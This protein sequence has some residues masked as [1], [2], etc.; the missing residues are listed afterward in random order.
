MYL[1][2]ICLTLIKLKNMKK[3]KLFSI[4]IALLITNIVSAQFSISGPTVVCVGS[5]T[6]YP[7]ANGEIP[8][9]YTFI[10]YGSVPLGIT[11]SSGANLL[12]SPTAIGT[13]E[14]IAY[15][16]YSKLIGHDTKTITEETNKIT[17][18]VVGQPQTPTVM[19][20]NFSPCGNSNQIYNV[21]QNPYS[22]Y[23]WVID[24]SVYNSKTD[25][26]NQTSINFKTDNLKKIYPIKVIVSQCGQS[27]FLEKNIVL[28][29]KPNPQTVISGANTLCELTNANNYSV[30]A[31]IDITNYCWTCQLDGLFNVIAN[32]NALSVNVGLDNSTNTNPVPKIL[33]VELNNM[34]G[35]TVIKK[36]IDI[37]KIPRKPNVINGIV[38]ITDVTVNYTYITSSNY[39]NK[40][41]WQISPAN[42]G[43]QINDKSGN[44][45]SLILNINKAYTGKINLTA[46]GNN[47]CGN[48]P[49]SDEFIINILPK[50]E[51]ATPPNGNLNACVNINDNYSST[52]KY[53]D[54]YE[55]ELSP[56]NAG[57][58]TINNDKCQ[59]DW[60][61]NFNGAA[62]LRVRG[63]NK[64]GQGEWSNNSNIVIYSLPTKPLAPSGDLILCKNPPSTTYTSATSFA[65]TYEW[66]L[67]PSNAGVIFNNNQ[68]AVVNWDDNY[69][70]KAYLRVK[71]INNCGKGEWSEFTEILISTTAQTPIINGNFRPCAG[72]TI[73]YNSN[74]SDSIFWSV[75]PPNAYTKLKVI[76]KN[77]LEITWNRDNLISSS[78]A[79]KSYSKS[80]CGTSDIKI[81]SIYI[82]RF[83]TTGAEPILLS[84]IKP[85]YCSSDSTEIIF[86]TINPLLWFSN[87]QQFAT[88]YKNTIYF[89]TGIKQINVTSL[90][91][92]NCYSA[93]KLINFNVDEVK[94]DFAANTIQ[95]NVGSRVEFKNLSSNADTYEW[96]F[97]DNSFTSNI[98]DDYHTFY[99]KGVFTIKLTAISKN[100]CQ[101]KMVKS[102]YITV[103]PLSIPEFNENELSIFPNPFINNIFIESSITDN[104]IITIT[105]IAG[106]TVFS[107]K[108]IKSIKTE[109]FIEGVYFIKIEST[110]KVKTYKLI[111]L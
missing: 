12:F 90:L 7:I 25:A 11:S 75:D 19:Y 82:N 29:Q 37:Y 15:K 83:S 5:K 14:L 66:E 68:S 35:Q 8:T 59:I 85:F 99:N 78:A 91:A 97:G 10:S 92:N 86:N 110:K 101:D 1:Y 76:S 3:L 21:D 60:N 52:S 98:K 53:A 81:D 23:E 89:K 51:K 84:T 42:A 20:G 63:I 28:N 13:Y 62:S 103:S 96:D 56:S 95:T 70:G 39:S 2:Y 100:K 104:Y 64:S 9:G 22:T 58:L 46:I 71:G 102:N 17:V 34:C 24:Q 111:K 40:I 18:T 41:I 4:L 26:K 31:D 69:I 33:T 48:S 50:P 107:N 49:I 108:N 6:Y 73:I 65:T 36:S 61:D 94:A 43:N 38:D 54:T 105:D 30:P 27:V 74:T 45:D 16:T 72:E 77:Q 57:T 93:A 88:G 44:N 55:W 32:Q 106:K 87:N 47:G 79:I 67:S 109:S 80:N